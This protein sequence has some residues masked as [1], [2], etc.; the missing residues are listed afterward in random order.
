[1]APSG[2]DYELTLRAGDRVVRRVYAEKRL[3][4]GKPLKG[5]EWLIK[6]SEVLSGRITSPAW[7]IREST[8]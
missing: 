4:E 1:M 7:K 5:E 3:F 6:D 2:L 8:E